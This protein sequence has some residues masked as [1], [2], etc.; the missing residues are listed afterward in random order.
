MLICIANAPSLHD[1]NISDC[2]IINS[3][4]NIVQAV[5]DG[6]AKQQQMVLWLSTSEIAGV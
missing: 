5:L 6:S 1:S 4:L 2:A 3:A